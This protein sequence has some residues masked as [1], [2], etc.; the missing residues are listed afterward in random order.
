MAEL[1]NVACQSSTR[2]FSWDEWQL[3][4]PGEAYRCTCGQ[5][6]AG[7]DA[8]AATAGCQPDS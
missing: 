2:N 6:P 7:K 1:I 3:Y 5:R 4:F 8:P